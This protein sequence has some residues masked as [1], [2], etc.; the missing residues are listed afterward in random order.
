MSDSRDVSTEVIST[1][2]AATLPPRRGRRMRRIAVA[3]T[4]SALALT[5]VATGVVSSSRMADD[6]ATAS[7]LSDAST[8]TATTTLDQVPSTQP[9]AGTMRGMMP[10]GG[11]AWSGGGSSAGGATLDDGSTLDGGASSGASG[12]AG[13]SGTTQTA[14]TEAG[15]D[16]ST[17]IVLIDTV[18]GYQDAEAAGTGMVLSSDGLVLTNNHVI[19]GSTEIEV[20]VAAT[21]ETYSA[22]V[23]GTDAEDDVALLQLDGASGLT[24]ITLDDDGVAIGDSVTAVGNAEGGGVLM[25]A[26]GSVTDLESTVTTAAEYSTESETLDGMIQFAADV[27]GGDS[28]GALIDDEGEV[29]GMTTAA[30]SGLATTIAFAVPIEDALAIVDQIQAGDESDG[31]TLGYGAFLGIGL[32]SDA[33]IGVTSDGRLGVV[34]SNDGAEIGYVFADTPAADAGLAAGDVI[35]AVDGVAVADGD[36][37]SAA[38]AEHDP[39]DTVTLTWTDAAGATQSATVTLAQGPAA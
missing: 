22:T 3:T 5:A 36:E 29:V 21:G 30:S 32:A 1:E 14:A 8:E 28:G 31:V 9:A 23:I 20:T 13:T 16:E 35:T 6:D 19:S 4:V 24:T 18:L 26:D 2:E 15:A 37:L 17:G 38:L 34:T 7:A 11:G 33:G 27:V 10:P 39:G 25:A 12:T